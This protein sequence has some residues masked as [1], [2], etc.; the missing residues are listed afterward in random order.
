M[1][2]PSNLNPN[3]ARSQ[4]PFSK[5]AIT[6]V[7]G[8]VAF[9]VTTLALTILLIAYP[10]LGTVGFALLGT[11]EVAS[12]AT[13]LV[14]LT[15]YSIKQRNAL[16][17]ERLAH[18]AMVKEIID[19]LKLAPP[20]IVEE[21]ELEESEFSNLDYIDNVRTQLPP[22]F[23]GLKNFLISFVEGHYIAAGQ[24]TKNIEEVA[25][26]VD[27]I[28][29]QIDEFLQ[30]PKE[31]LR[32]AIGVA[33]YNL[34]DEEKMGALLEGSNIN[35]IRGFSDALGEEQGAFK[36]QATVTKQILQ[37]L[38]SQ[39]NIVDDELVE[40]IQAV[41]KHYTAMRQDR[42]FETNLEY[43]ISMIQMIDCFYSK[44]VLPEERINTWTT[45]LIPPFLENW[46]ASFFERIGANVQVLR[47][48]FSEK[49]AFNTKSYYWIIYGGSSWA[50][51]GK[52]ASTIQEKLRPFP[53][54]EE[55]KEVLKNAFK[56][57]FIGMA[58]SIL[59]MF[60]KNAPY[61]K[62]VEGILNPDQFALPQPAEDNWETYIKVYSD[63][64]NTQANKLVPR[65]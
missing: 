3:V 29:N 57:L 19:A 28:Q 33:S 58:D 64:F 22:L 18:D 26:A 24:R 14:G 10:S 61:R 59:G 2:I 21:V 37:T 25:T 49:G 16:V 60:T 9:A 5:E 30:N 31:M 11:L 42:N 23:D 43:Q 55:R 38:S 51:K 44:A 17:E 35:L 12:L 63:F 62:Q 8:G 65:D 56:D 46:R 15:L 7:V 52:L 36:N 48:A 53:L 13:T 27:Q 4:L 54:I 50:G 40:K 39:Y 1:S 32:I 6:T 20:V 41:R 45:H 34:I 47:D